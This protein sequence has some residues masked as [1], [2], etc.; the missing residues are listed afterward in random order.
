MEHELK[1]VCLNGLEIH[2][3]ISE[4]AKLRLHIFHDYPYLYDGDM[5]YETKYLNKYLQC[6]DSVMV[7]ALDKEKVVG[8][9]TAIPLEF[10][11]P[12]VQKPFLDHGINIHDVFYFGESVLLS[13]YRGK[14]IY[15]HFFQEREK[16][17]KEYGCKIAAFCAVVRR[18]DDPRRPKDYLPIDIIW[19]RYGYVKH[20]E[21]CAYIEWKEI[22]EDTQSAKPLI[23]WLKTL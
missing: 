14:N 10:E 22:G 7:L 13:T 6:P 21:L 2:P 3:Y 5:E 15:Q 20:P 12:E 9:S 17:A 8:A 4:L 23:F 19:Q 18:D 16:A 1:I 11:T